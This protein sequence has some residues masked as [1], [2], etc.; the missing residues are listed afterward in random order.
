VIATLCTLLV[1]KSLHEQSALLPFCL[2]SGF[3]VI[4]RVVS[5]INKGGRDLLNFRLSAFIQARGTPTM[6]GVQDVPGVIPRDSAV[7][8]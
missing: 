4:F 6:G 5:G 2:Y 7:A 3:G 1:P 8:G